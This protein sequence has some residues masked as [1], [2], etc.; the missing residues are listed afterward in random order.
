[1]GESIVGIAL[2]STIRIDYPTAIASIDRSSD[3][4]HRERY[5][6]CALSLAN[7]PK[8]LTR[9]GNTQQTRTSSKKT[10]PVDSTGGMP[11]ARDGAA[12]GMFIALSILAGLCATTARAHGGGLDRNGCHHE[13]KHGGY[14]CH[15]GGGPAPSTASPLRFDLSSDDAGAAPRPGSSRPFANCAEA[16]AAGAAP[17]RRGDPGYGPH[18]N[19]DGDGVG[20]ENR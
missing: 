6:P 7:A 11:M 3:F 14:H 8:R 1:L 18:L 16:R 17:V 13:R 15:R 19:R 2:D 20:C 10:K 9:A 4:L 5:S 12:A